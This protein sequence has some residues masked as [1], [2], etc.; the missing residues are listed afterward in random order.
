MA[1][2][3]ARAIFSRMKLTDKAV[4]VIVAS[5][6]QGLIKMDDFA[7][8]NDKSAESICRVLIRP[9]GNI[10]EVSNP[11]GWSQPY[12]TLQPQD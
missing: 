3:G 9:G 11:V 2:S 5:Y 10:G 4:A 12:L 7:Q 1:T 8:L 6:I